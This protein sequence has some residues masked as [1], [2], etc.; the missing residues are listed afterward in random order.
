LNSW[1]F[2]GGIQPRKIGGFKINTET[3]PGS[4]PLVSRN[5]NLG[6]QI[7]S[8]LFLIAGH[9]HHFPFLSTSEIIEIP[10]RFSV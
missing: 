6:W 7:A 10:F 8:Y 2:S 9:S 1:Q 3:G 4:K 5:Q